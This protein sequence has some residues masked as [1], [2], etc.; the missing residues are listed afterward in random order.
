MTASRRREITAAQRLGLFGAGLA[1]L[2][3]LSFAVAG[4]V[5]PDGA[6]AAWADAPTAQESGGHAGDAPVTGD[7]GGPGADGAAE[8]GAGTHGGD[9]AAHVRGLGLEQDGLLLGPVGAPGGTGRAGVLSFEV[10]TADGEPVTDFATEHDKKL[11]LVVVRSDGALFRH[12]HPTM[13]DD[14][15][16]SLPWTWAE[17]GTYRVLADFVPERTGENVTLGR[18]VEVAGDLVPVPTASG[19]AS[20]TESDTVDG[21]TVTLDGALVAGGESVLTA[22]VTR[23]GEPVTDLEPYLGAFGHLVVLREGDLGYLHVHPEAQPDGAEPRPGEASGPEVTFVTSAPTPGR[24][25]LYLDFKVDGEVRT[26]HL[27][28]DAPA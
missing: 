4:L 12:V 13:S 14:G 11:H 28:L 15:V 16:W 18:T 24:Y 20:G 10:T 5:V 9:G 26:A 17:A 7:H 23:D 3:A 22:R 21:Y 8:A 25:L 19:T 1:A 6:A 27:V 2:F